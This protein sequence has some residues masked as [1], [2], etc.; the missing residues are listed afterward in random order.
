MKGSHLSEQEDRNMENRDDG[1][2]HPRRVHSRK[3]EVS[4]TAWAGI[5]LTVVT[6]CLSGFHNWSSDIVRQIERFEDRVAEH[7]KEVDR[8]L[9]KLEERRR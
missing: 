8:R 6:L 1:P 3:A 4:Y 9:L 2:Y 5:I 7:L